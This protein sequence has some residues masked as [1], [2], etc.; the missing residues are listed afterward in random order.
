MQRD[1]EPHYSLSSVKAYIFDGDVT[2]G[3]YPF[4]RWL[5]CERSLAVLKSWGT[6]FIDPQV[7]S[8]TLLSDTE[9]MQ[10]FTLDANGAQVPNTDAQRDRYVENGNALAQLTIATS[11]E[12]QSIVLNSRTT[13]NGTG[14][15][16][17]AVRNL[18]AQ[19]QGMD[20]NDKILLEKRYTSISLDAEDLNP[21][22]YLEELNMV[23]EILVE[24]GDPQKSDA[25]RKARILNGLPR[26]YEH[27][28]HALETTENE[29][30][31]LTVAQ[32]RLRVKKYW[33][34]KLM[35]QRPHPRE[36]LAFMTRGRRAPQRAAPTNQFQP[37]RFQQPQSSP[38]GRGRG[39]GSSQAP[40]RPNLRYPQPR[41]NQGPA[42][43]SYFTVDAAEALRCTVCSGPHH[44]SHCLR[45]KNKEQ[46]Q[47]RAHNNP[48]WRDKNRN[49]NFQNTYQPRNKMMNSSYNQRN[50]NVFRG[51][52]KGVNDK[53]QK[54]CFGCGKPN[55]FAAQCPN[56]EPNGGAFYAQANMVTVK[57]E[58][59]RMLDD[60]SIS[61]AKSVHVEDDLTTETENTEDLFKVSPSSSKE[62]MTCKE[63]AKVHEDVKSFDSSDD[64]LDLVLRAISKGSKKG[65]E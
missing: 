65:A 48:N 56:R 35:G 42:S 12:A 21:H 28:T 60:E 14:D 57:T 30:N 44:W 40:S 32:L 5:A 27:F 10:G 7:F 1:D 11:G 25:S 17:L 43:S 6:V 26:A 50:K 15:A 3:P 54:V 36:P 53:G 51:K 58:D 29:L 41:R 9:Y 24:L 18:L 39:R 38:H 13:R 23:E 4:R 45:R 8:D 64:D 46:N 61:M 49:N 63:E 47:S 37:R 62:K 16:G 22:E 59:G 33:R 2:R 34:A 55:H 52:Q 31:A 19:Y 20:P